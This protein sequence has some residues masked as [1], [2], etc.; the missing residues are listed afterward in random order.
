MEGRLST[1]CASLD[2]ILGGGFRLGDVSLIY[3]EASTGKTTL[4]VSCV[5]EHLH[6]ERW[7]KAYYIDSDGKLSTKRLTQIAGDHEALERLLIWRPRGFR[8]QTEI[9]EGLSDIPIGNDPVVIDSI[10]G[11]YRLEAGRPDRTFVVN[12]ELNRQLGFLSETAKTR[13]A[14]V[15][16][17]GQVHGVM[18]S[19]ASQVEPVAQRLLMYWS[20][21]IVKLETTSV[22]GVRQAVLEKPESRSR[23]CRFRLG[24]TGVQEVGRPW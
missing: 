6:G 1:G 22:T 4:A 16:V 24:D 9:V 12:K 20:D 15:L 7:A 14:A 8:E 17:V 21:T 3:G 2:D 5:A 11:P 10:T 13:E 18:G 23:A 19:E